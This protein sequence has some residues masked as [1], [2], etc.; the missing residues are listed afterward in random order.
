VPKCGRQVRGQFEEVSS[1]FPPRGF[2]KSNQDLRVWHQTP[3]P[4]QASCQ[5]ALS[6]SVESFNE[7]FGHG[8]ENKVVF[9]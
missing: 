4:T 7:V 1:L 2:Q 5:S 8:K 6:D 3:L 9:L